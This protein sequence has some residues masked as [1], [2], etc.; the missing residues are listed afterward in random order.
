M[1]PARTKA[2][3]RGLLPLSSTVAC[4][5]IRPHRG[6]YPKSGFAA[7]RQGCMKS[8]T[9]TSPDLRSIANRL[10]YEFA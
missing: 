6:P 5:T 8:L 7:T 1:K 9:C 10:E 3:P 4:K 2:K